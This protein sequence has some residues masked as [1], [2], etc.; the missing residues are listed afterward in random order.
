M[1][2]Q[3]TPPTITHLASV[4]GPYQAISE[5]TERVL[6]TFRSEGHDPFTRRDVVGVL[7]AL[8]GAPHLDRIVEAEKLVDAVIYQCQK[9]DGKRG[10]YTQGEKPATFT[11]PTPAPSPTAPASIPA[12]ISVPTGVN[13]VHKA[14]LSWTP[15][16][17]EGDENLEGYYKDDVGLRRLAITRTKCFG[18]HVS[19]DSACQKCPLAQ[20]CSQGTVS[21]MESIADKLDRETAKAIE[22]AEMRV[23]AARAAEVR[24]E[25]ARLQAAKRAANPAPPTP[26]RAPTPPPRKNLLD[27]LPAGHTVVDLPF[28]GV[29]SKCSN[30]IPADS[31]AIHVAG[32]GMFHPTCA[33]D[34]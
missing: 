19:T 11:V 23:A 25:E 20:W 14:G 6:E 26:P 24:A 32:T 12:P 5:S 29:C 9:V 22:Q 8:S 18:D 13:I 7:A 16:V 2:L 27:N 1:R 34:L 4:A 3:L 33:K 10:Y 21:A 17:V 30:G 15:T 28:E 31:Q